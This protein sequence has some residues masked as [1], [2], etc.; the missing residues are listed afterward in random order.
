MDAGAGPDA[1]PVL[2]QDGKAEDLL[3]PQA[4]DDVEAVLAVGQPGLEDAALVRIVLKPQQVLL[5][6]KNEERQ[7]QQVG[8][9]VGIPQH[10]PQPGKEPEDDLGPGHDGSSM[11]PALV[12][13]G[14]FFSVHADAALSGALFVLGFPGKTGVSSG[15]D[16][17][18][19]WRFLVEQ[20]GRCSPPPSGGGAAACRRSQRAQVRWGTGL[21]VGRD[22]GP[23]PD[24]DR[25]AASERCAS[26]V[27]GRRTVGFLSRGHSRPCAG[28]PGWIARDSHL[29]R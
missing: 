2:G 10:R 26:P 7:L 16:S 17:A 5:V 3:G 14:N 4:D 11:S 18:G 23:P 15:P 25:P 8:E 6:L 20:R 27:R 12:A 13:A 1:G 22:G 9:A 29:S 24:L 28:N 21:S 19:F